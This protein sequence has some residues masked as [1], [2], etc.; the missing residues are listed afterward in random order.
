M[1][2]VYRTPN[3]PIKK[4]KMTI[5]KLIFAFYVLSTSLG[6]VFIK[7]GSSDGFPI[8]FISGKL[9]FNL[10]FYIISGIVLY[11][12]SFVLY[13]YLISR[14]DL[15][16]IIPLTTAIVYV[17]IFIAS[18]FIFHEAFTVAKVMG[19]VLI[20]GGVVLLNLK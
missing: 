10:N 16:Y 12:L 20:L 18:F 13:I 1:T 15:G 2:I 19:I 8:K 5:S 17:L 7:L 14:H 6:L 11:I 3:T 9:S 4:A